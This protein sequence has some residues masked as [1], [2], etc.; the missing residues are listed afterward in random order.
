MFTHIHHQD[1]IITTYGYGLK[2][3]YQASRSLWLISMDSDRS[4][5]ILS[6]KC[7]FK[8]KTFQLE[9]AAE[10]NKIPADFISATCLS[11]RFLVR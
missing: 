11:K 5:N 3:Q 8:T 6:F 4:Q 1:Q 9:K 10:R 2:N 7:S